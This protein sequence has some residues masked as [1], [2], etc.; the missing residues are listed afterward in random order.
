MHERVERIATRTAYLHF[1]IQVP[2]ARER[3]DTASLFD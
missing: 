2:V 1:G 3:P